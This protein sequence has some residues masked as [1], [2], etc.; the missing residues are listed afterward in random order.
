MFDS[1]LQL[2]EEWAV[3][4]DADASFLSFAPASAS[5]VALSEVM[6]SNRTFIRFFRRNEPGVFPLLE[7]APA[8]GSVLV[9]PRFELPI[10]VR[11]LGEHSSPSLFSVSSSQT[12]DDRRAA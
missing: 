9:S 12:V 10:R 5:E 4:V 6:V 8:A 7:L 3:H 11:L 1:F 2:A